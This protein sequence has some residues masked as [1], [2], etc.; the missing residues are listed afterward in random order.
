MQSILLLEKCFFRAASAS[1]SKDGFLSASSSS[2]SNK[3]ATLSSLSFSFSAFRATLRFPDKGRGAISLTLTVPALLGAKGR[4]E[5]AAIISDPL[6]HGRSPAEAAT[7]GGAWSVY[8][9][10]STSPRRIIIVSATRNLGVEGNLDKEERVQMQ[11]S[12]KGQ[13]EGRRQTRTPMECTSSSSSSSSEE[14]EERGGG[15]SKIRTRTER[16]G[17][18]EG[19]ARWRRCRNGDRDGDGKGIQF[20]TLVAR[21]NTA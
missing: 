12:D 3:D 1:S 14:E 19:G 11:P 21:S 13:R 18:G 16:E 17:G 5:S 10:P 9:P 4:G 2:E 6:I 20:S 15:A 7:H 8:P